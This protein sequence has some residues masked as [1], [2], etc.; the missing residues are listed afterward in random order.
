MLRTR[1]VLE[2]GQTSA[3]CTMTAA[4]EMVIGVFVPHSGSSQA[5]AESPRGLTMRADGSIRRARSNEKILPTRKSRD[6]TASA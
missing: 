2:N 4:G 1:I 3:V 5:E 6:H